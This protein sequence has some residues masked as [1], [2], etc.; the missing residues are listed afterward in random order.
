[1][2]L[3]IYHFIRKHSL[4]RKTF[5]NVSGQTAVEYILLL[6]VVVTMITALAKKVKD[7]FSLPEGVTC[8]ERPTA[9]VCQFRKPLDNSNYRY[10]S[11]MK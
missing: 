3:S 1:M 8:E 2:I 5:F 7:H 4:V 10:F 9:L 6:M 11:I